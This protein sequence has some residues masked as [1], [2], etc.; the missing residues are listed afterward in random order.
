MEV[1]SCA[2][3]TAALVPSREV[4]NRV[5]VSVIWEGYS[6][7]YF[8]KLFEALRE[9][10]IPCHGRSRAHSA[11]VLSF[12]PLAVDR[13]FFRNARDITKQMGWELNVLESDLPAARSIAD[14]MG[15]P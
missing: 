15:A 1:T 6:Q 10:R 3:C 14:Q 9:A 5:H 8:G 11:G 7:D 12:L 4:A 13:F 2:D